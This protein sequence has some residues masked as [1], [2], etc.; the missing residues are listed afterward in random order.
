VIFVTVGT[1]EQPMDRLLRALDAL[2][3]EVVPADEPIVV[4]S[5]WCTHVARRCVTTKLMPFEEVQRHMREARIVVTHGGPASIMQALAHGKVPIVVPRRA[6]HGEHVDDH[7][8]LFSRR[9]ADRVVVVL[10]VDELADAIARHGARVA[11]L[12]PE[13]YGPERARAFALRFD[14]L[15]RDLV[16]S[17]PSRR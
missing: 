2:P 3:P 17:H 7:Q 6:A 14:T 10:E 4:Q 13:A 5:G 9:I 8:V 15:C 16:A 12:G 11:A 1:H